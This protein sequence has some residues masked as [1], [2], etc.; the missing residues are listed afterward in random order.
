MATKNAST[1]RNVSNMTQDSNMV[2]HPPLSRAG[3]RPIISV[4]K[5][6]RLPRYNFKIFRSKGALIALL[7]C[8]CALFVYNLLMLHLPITASPLLDGNLAV[9]MG[10]FLYPVSGW[11]AD[12]HFGRYGVIKWSLRLLWFASITF[13]S[14][15]TLLTYLPLPSKSLLAMKWIFFPIQFFM[16]WWCTVQHGSVC[17]RPACRCIL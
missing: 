11:L 13:C 14:I 16:P 4:T 17:R 3:P 2:R 7:L 5:K 8:F 1:L 6:L 10:L 15:Y 9:N 12:V